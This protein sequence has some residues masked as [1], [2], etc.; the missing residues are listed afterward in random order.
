FTL[1]SVSASSREAEKAGRDDPQQ[2]PRLR[3][4][5]NESCWSGRPFLDAVEVTLG[6][7][8]LKALLDLQL[9]KTDLGELSVETAKRAQQ[10][11][12]KFYASAPLT[13]YALRF[14]G[15]GKSESDQRLRRAGGP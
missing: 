1:E 3:F 6:V 12:L 5:F 8:P 14:A 7:P 2:T 9:G 15:E 11:N 13:L 10:T 4:R